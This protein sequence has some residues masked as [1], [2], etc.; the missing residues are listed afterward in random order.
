MFDRQACSSIRPSEEPVADL[1][2][3]R[4]PRFLLAE[5]AGIDGADRPLSTTDSDLSAGLMS[6]DQNLGKDYAPNSNEAGPVG[7]VRSVEKTR[8]LQTPQR[9][10]LPD[11][12]RHKITRLMARLLM[13]HGSKGVAVSGE[14]VPVSRQTR[15][16]GDVREDST[17]S[18]GA[19]GYGVFPDIMGQSQ[20]I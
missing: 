18:P 5:F 12:T 8:P 4:A 19:Q 15:E 3:L 2:A 1:S 20:L 11:P 7:F 9:H 13:A 14:E 10:S 17:P 6:C 16:D